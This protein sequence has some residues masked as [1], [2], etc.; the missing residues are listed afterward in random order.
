[1]RN[2]SSEEK[3]SNDDDDG[4]VYCFCTSSYVAPSTH[5]LWGAD[6]DD[7][8]GGDAAEAEKKHF[9]LRRAVGNVLLEC[10]PIIGAS[11]FTILP[12]SAA[13]RRW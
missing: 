1:M 7:D 4:N 10:T 11:L 6:D 9:P 13:E 5:P 8:V 12:D 2:G 3:K